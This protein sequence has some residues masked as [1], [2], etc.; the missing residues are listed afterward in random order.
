MMKKNR[1]WLD[2]LV[3][4][5]SLCAL[6]AIAQPA[7]SQ[8][9]F[10]WR[11]KDGTRYIHPNFEIET[12]AVNFG[13]AGAGTG[14]TEQDPLSPFLWFDQA[15][16][17]IHYT[18]KWQIGTLHGFTMPEIP[19]PDVS[20]I[21]ASGWSLYVDSTSH[22]LSCKLKNG[23]TCL[24]ASSA[25][26]T[27]HLPLSCDSP[28]GTGN[29]FFQPIALS[30]WTAGVYQFAPTVDGTVFCTIRIPATVAGSPNA[31]V[32]LEWG[33]NNT[34]ASKGVAW[35]VSTGKF[36]SGSTADI[37]L[38]AETQQ[39]IS[40]PTTAYQRIDTTFPAASNIATAVAAGD[41]LVVKIVRKGSDGVND[42]LTTLNALLF[43][44]S[45]RIDLT[46]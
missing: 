4:L 24:P 43:K 8:E 21:V 41:E 14:I 12:G 15:T 46:E 2:L 33:A 19:A 37:S 32:I 45:L 23:S 10:S 7:Q 38:T 6:L 20:N 40:V 28:D 1:I 42:T 17:T 18:L 16:G 34:A 27:H 11:V 22:A 44:A 36:A 26:A 25:T 35:T 39:N 13:A 29:A 5:L 3:S 31:A 9:M 30:S